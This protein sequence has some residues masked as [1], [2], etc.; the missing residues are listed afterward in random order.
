M[1]KVWKVLKLFVVGALAGVG[2]M[3]LFFIIL[4]MLL[5][6]SHDDVALNDPVADSAQ[7][8]QEADLLEVYS[9][10]N[11][12]TVFYKG[13]VD[14]VSTDKLDDSEI[15]LWVRS[16]GR[17]DIQVVAPDVCSYRKGQR[18]RFTPYIL[19][20]D[21]ERLFYTSCLKVKPRKAPKQEVPRNIRPRQ[22]A[23]VFFLFHSN[24]KDFFNI[25]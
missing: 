8:V 5:P 14:S 25:S 19:A 1:A 6:D 15:L 24:S 13:K 22:F 17:N 2:S 7:N 16:Q 20:D 21:G 11:F 9:D 10:P 3:M 18:I 4:L 23:G 12:N